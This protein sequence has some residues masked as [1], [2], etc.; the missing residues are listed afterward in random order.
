M[1]IRVVVADRSDFKVLAEFI[2]LARA[3]SR[4]ESP[5]IHPKDDDPF[6]LWAEEFDAVALLMGSLASG[7]DTFL[8]AKDEDGKALGYLSYRNECILGLAAR[9]TGL[10]TGFFVPEEHRRRFVPGALIR[11][12]SRIGKAA[13]IEQWQAIVAY[14]TSNIHGMLRRT[15]WLP[16]AA[17]YQHEGS[18]IHVRPVQRNQESQQDGKPGSQDDRR[19]R[20]RVSGEPV[21]REHDG[22]AV[23]LACEPG[24]ADS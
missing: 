14:G 9:K 1:S 20:G 18:A 19:G 6:R 10:I 22:V 16:V 7:N 15:G 17:I 24:I 3:S 12:L 21:G 2:R 23:G 5:E 13:G 8:L 4:S 11:A